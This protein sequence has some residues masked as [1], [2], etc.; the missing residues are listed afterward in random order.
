[1]RD[2]GPCTALGPPARGSSAGTGASG[3]NVVGSG[4]RLATGSRRTSRS[5]T[6]HARPGVCS[7]D[8]SSGT[9]PQDGASSLT[10]SLLTCYVARPLLWHGYYRRSNLSALNQYLS[11]DMNERHNSLAHGHKIGAWVNK[12]YTHTRNSSM[13]KFYQHMTLS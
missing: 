5:S 3:A 6:S 8:S 1:M 2:N 4:Q 12:V 13:E 10:S 11:R 9:G 7:Q